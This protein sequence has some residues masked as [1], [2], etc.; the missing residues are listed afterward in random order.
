M[1]IR[2]VLH[3]AGLASELRVSTVIGAEL[4]LNYAALSIK[5]VIQGEERYR[6]RGR[7]R[8]VRA[9]EHLLIQGGGAGEVIIG[10]HEARGICV[11]IG[12]PMLAEVVRHHAQFDDRVEQRLLQ[13]DYFDGERAPLGRR[14][15]AVLT[16]LAVGATAL[17]ASLFHGLAEAVLLD[18]LDWH[19]LTQRL[20]ARKQGTQR[21]T[22]RKLLLARAAFDRDP[23]A[24]STAR[25]LAVAHGFSEFHFSRAFAAVFGGSPYAYMLQV[26]LTEACRLLKKGGRPVADVALA[27]GFNDAATFARAFKRHHGRSPSSFIDRARMVK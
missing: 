9:G 12:A 19:G 27:C 13:A 16:A 6:V 2:T 20:R 15:T 3:D 1:D 21:E 23:L 11:D 24:F 17:D 14:T 18:R 22:V 25:E 7:L 8:T 10:P 5:H 4:P 26:R